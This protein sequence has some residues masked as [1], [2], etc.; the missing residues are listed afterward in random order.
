MKIKRIAVM[1]MIF[2]VCLLFLAGCA[3]FS[4][5][6]KEARIRFS[7]YEEKTDSLQ[8]SLGKITFIDEGQGKPLLI[9]HGICGG[10][11]QAYD[12]ANEIREDFRVIAPSRFGYPGSD[13]PKEATT[14]MQVQAFLELL[15]FLNIKKTYLLA[16]S[17]GST[18]AIKFALIHPERTKGLILYC[19]GFPATEAR[20]KKMKYAG[21]PS[22]F[23]SDFAMWLISP[24][25]KP[26]MGMS[27]DTLKEILPMKD[28]EA[29]VIFDAK[30][31]NTVMINNYTEYDLSELEVP[32]LIIHAKDDKLADFNKVE[33]WVPRIKNCTFVPL[34]S[35]GHLM[36]DNGEVI[37]N[38][39]KDFLNENN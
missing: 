33:A 36:T 23:C 11:D 6:K 34:E 21:P 19:S 17:A 2:I 9:C 5:V 15:D 4:K 14:E 30:V 39:V 37:R 20:K 1:I 13:L 25:F 24:L 38:A 12:A 8:T 27:P 7:G 31:T 29:G 22:L 26:L 10:Y 32:V 16:T 18:V 35:G 28:R 3:T